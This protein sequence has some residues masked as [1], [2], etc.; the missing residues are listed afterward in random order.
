MKRYRVAFDYSAENPTNAVIYLLGIIEDPNL[1]D[2]K[3][4]W[5]V[6]DLDSG[7]EHKLIYSLNELNAIARQ[8]NKDFLDGLRDPEAN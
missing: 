3:I 5:L 1:Q 7:E 6:T 2:M 4:N 8:E